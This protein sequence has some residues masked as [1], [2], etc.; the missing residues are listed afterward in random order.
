MMTDDKIYKVFVSSTFEDLR[1]DRSQVQLTLLKPDCLPVG[2]ELFPAG[3]EETWRFIERQIEDTDYY[4]VVIAGR[5]GS[6][7]P[8][9]ISYT[10]KEYDYAERAGKPRL[11]FVHSNPMSLPMSH[12]E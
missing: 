3:D 10:E 4:F 8:G 9:G 7:H 11:A 6:L 12:S 5:Y 1:E 2:M